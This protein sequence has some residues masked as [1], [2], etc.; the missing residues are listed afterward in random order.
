MCVPA[1]MYM[2]LWICADFRACIYAYGFK[3]TSKRVYLC[4]YTYAHTYTCIRMC[5]QL[6]T[7]S[8]GIPHSIDRTYTMAPGDL[9][10]MI[11]F[12]TDIRTHSLTR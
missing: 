12:G 5:M 10:A 4:M 2:Y 3:Y 8:C 11:F 7:T 6:T 1:Y 9:I